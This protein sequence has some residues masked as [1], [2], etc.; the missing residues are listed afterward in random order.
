[1]ISSFLHSSSPESL[2]HLRD[3]GGDLLAVFDELDSDAFA[4]GGVGLLG[5]HADLLQH[6]AFDVGGA[7][8]GVG[9]QGGAR[10]RLL[11]I[12]VRPSLHPTVSADLAGRFDATRFSHFSWLT[13]VLPLPKI[14]V[15]KEGS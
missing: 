7:A 8:E 2:S 3:E 5:L 4:N 11:V 1:M 14:C 9:L 12:L 13:K 15:N 6:D 10:V